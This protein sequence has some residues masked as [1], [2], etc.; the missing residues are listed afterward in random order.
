MRISASQAYYQGTAFLSNEEYDALFGEGG[1]VG[2]GEIGEFP[3]MRPM[4]SLQKYY[5]GEGEPPLTGNLIETPKFDGSAVSLLYSDGV[6]IRALTRGDGDKGR[7]VTEK[8]VLLVPPTIECKET[9]QITGEVVASINTTNSRNFSNG[10][11]NLKNIE[12]FKDRMVE[13]SLVFAAYGLQFD[14]EELDNYNYSD[15]LFSLRSWG[16]HTVSS[17]DSTKYPT[18][19][20]VLRL[21][22]NVEY[23]RLGFTAKHPRGAYAEKTRDTPEVTKLLD[24]IWQTGKSGKVTPVAVLSPIVIDDAVITRATLNNMAYI[25][26]LG[27]E[28]GCM[29]KVIR[30]GK[31][32][33]CIVGRAD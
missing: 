32:I 4:Y 12:E 16:F 10:A 8:L 3:H 15:D 6:F 23:K 14:N 5:V 33:P 24:V 28:I 26:A 18:D 9:I 11:L 22:D 20:K 2:S 17:L 29:V 25:D 27:L 19:G 30:A 31:I 13:G 21:Q 7:P 1:P